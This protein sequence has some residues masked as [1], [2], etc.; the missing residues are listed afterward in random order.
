ADFLDFALYVIILGVLYVV[1]GRLARGARPPDAA[2]AL[3][4]AGPLM[5]TTTDAGQ[6]AVGSGA[7]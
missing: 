6:A 5:K 3:P 7:R 4:E 1:T 2:M